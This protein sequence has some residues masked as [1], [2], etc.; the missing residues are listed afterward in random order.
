M[1]SDGWSD[2]V[3]N[4]GV[5]EDWLADVTDNPTHIKMFIG[6]EGWMK[7]GEEKRREDTVVKS[8]KKR[9]RFSRQYWRLKCVF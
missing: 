8:Q 9:L 3:E 7:D 5:S 1:L 6:S 2:R 4:S